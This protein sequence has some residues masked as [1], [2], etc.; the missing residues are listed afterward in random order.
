MGKPTT[1]LVQD[2]AEDG[3]SVP[4]PASRV[5]YRVLALACALAVV[6]YI[7]RIGF[8]VGAPEIKRSLGLDDAQVGYLMS[9]FLVAYGCFQVP[10]GLLGDRFG[11]RHVLAILVLAWSLLT[12]AVALAVFLPH[13]AA[14]P[15]VFLLVLRFLFGMF[16]AGGFPTL[17]RVIA[18]WMP[19]TERGFAQGAIWMFSRWGGALIPFLLAWLFG[20]CGSWPV[21]FVL[22]AVLGVV[23]CA[24]FWPW[25]RNRPEEM[26]QVNRAERK[27]IAAGRSSVRELPGPVP[28]L[29]MVGSLNVWS[30]CLM[31]GFTGFSGNFFTNM[32]PLYL[33]EHRHLPADGAAWRWLSA[34]PLAAGSLA[35]ILGGFASDWAIRRWGNRKWGRRYI[36]LLGLGMAGPAFLATLWTQNLWMLGLLLTLTFFG[37]DLSMGPAWASCADIGE[38]YTGTLSGTMNMVSALAGACGTALAGYWFRQGHP[39]LVFLVFAGIYVLAA[40]CWLGVD[41]TRR[42]ADTP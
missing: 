27:L 41:V 14:L 19:V 7:Q 9:A 42:L 39:E 18:D 15:F 16:Q 38:R 35:C 3:E 31:Y 24:A 33:S 23:W 4:T 22:I 21:P 32:L 37:N 29:R 17:G 28:W 2:I 1:L 11:G 26:R 25:F 40:L 30:L 34:L 8:S 12:G 36:G 20:I 6:T 10:G 13:V 5:R